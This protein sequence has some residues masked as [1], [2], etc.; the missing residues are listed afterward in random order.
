MRAACVDEPPAQLATTPCPLCASADW[1]VVLHAPSA[2]G[3]AAGWYQVVRCNACGHRFTNPRPGP[4]DI[5]LFYPRDYAPHRADDASA[6]SPPV[7]EPAVGGARASSDSGDK[8]TPWYLARTVRAIPGVRRLYYWL[9]SDRVY[10]IPELPRPGARALEVGCAHGGFLARLE[11]LGWRAEGVEP[12]AAAAKLARARGFT[13]HVGT[14]DSAGLESGDYDAAFAWMVVEHLH[15][16]LATLGELHRLLAQGGWLALSVPDFDCWER[17]VFGRYWYALDLPIHLQHF[18]AAAIGGALDRSGFDVVRVCHQAH[19]LTLI[20]SLGLWLR[21]WSPTRRMGDW[22]VG[23][24][25]NPRLWG[26]VLLAPPAKCLAALG[27]T[28]YLTILARKR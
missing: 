17:R 27:Q 12:A 20:G 21:R 18:S 23:Y 2:L 10:F 5:G 11:A 13:V 6:A 1:T 26:Q 8:A 7:Q 25:A 22:L 28:G 24:C 4:D 9:R 16:P 15:D 19:L 14:L 3:R